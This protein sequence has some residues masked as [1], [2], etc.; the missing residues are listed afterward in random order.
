VTELTAV[1]VRTAVPVAPE[2]VGVL[3]PLAVIYVV[4]T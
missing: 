2:A 1:P 3:S 4:D